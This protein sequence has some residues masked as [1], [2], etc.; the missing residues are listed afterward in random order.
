MHG[1]LR[2]SV[3]PDRQILADATPLLKGLDGLPIHG[4][5]V[6]RLSLFMARSWILDRKKRTNGDWRIVRLDLLSGVYQRFCTG[7]NNC[8]WMQTF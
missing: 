3:K 2:R 5:R 1:L 4:S 6:A 8:F 7:A